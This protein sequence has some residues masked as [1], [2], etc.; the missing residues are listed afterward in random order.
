MG[1][2]TQRVIIFKILGVEEGGDSVHVPEL[3]TTVVFYSRDDKYEQAA[4]HTDRLAD[5]ITRIRKNGIQMPDG[6]KVEVVVFY[7]GT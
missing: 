1:E 4:N 3:I 7:G 2:I 5:D 6:Q